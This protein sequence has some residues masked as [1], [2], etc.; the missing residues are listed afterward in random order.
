METRDSD[1]SEL[2]QRLAALGAIDRDAELVVFVSE[3]CPFCARAVEHARQVAAASPR[4]LLEIVDA[5]R[6]RERALAES[7]ASVPLTVLDGEL[8]RTGVISP[9]ELATWILERGSP[10]HTARL[11]VSSL[12]D[13]RLDEATRR[14][15]APGGDRAFARAWAA[16]AMSQRM[17]LM[18]A[19]EDVLAAE[20]RALDD[21]VADLVASL[22]AG[23]AALRGDTA[24]L[25]GRIGHPAARPALAA[26][27]EDPD[28]D[29][30][31]AVTEAL[32]RL[33][34]A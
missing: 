31:E 9:V 13:G 3:S 2:N 30:A 8:R 1:A 16:S 4:I 27:E 29:V 34:E 14:V 15:L 18:A 32:E 23:D 6:E 7:V 5:G 19:L 17:G 20:P 21:V 10:A 33:R 22:E 24:D 12:D 28:P 26:H 25:L 11:L